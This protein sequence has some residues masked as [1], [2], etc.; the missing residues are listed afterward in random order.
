MDL[1]TSFIWL[2]VGV[3]FVA[4]EAFGISGIGFLFAGLAALCVG[5]I[6][7]LGVI[8]TDNQVL[9]GA[10]FCGLTAAWAAVLWKPM[11][12]FRMS[13]GKHSGGYSNMVGEIAIVS[14]AGLKAGAVGDVVWSGTIM[15]AELSKAAGEVEVAA[16]SAVVIKDVRGTT[17]IVEP[18]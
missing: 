8:G 16:G 14:N 10:L 5:V 7:E 15:K 9:Q 6:V 1:S 2:I 3:A 11:R 12:K 17:L 18:K 13:F 4:L